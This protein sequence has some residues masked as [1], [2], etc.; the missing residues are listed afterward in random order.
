LVCYCLYLF[1]QFFHPHF[2]FHLFSFLHTATVQV[3]EFGMSTHQST[4]KKKAVIMPAPEAAAS[5]P[6][7]IVKKV[8]SDQVIITAS[9]DGSIQKV[10]K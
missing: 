3:S 9:M 7:G 1:F 4:R 10:S 5:V 8:P 2:F 6:D